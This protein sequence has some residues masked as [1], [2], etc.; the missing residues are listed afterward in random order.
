MNIK[1]DRDIIT[2]NAMKFMLTIIFLS[3]YGLVC[4]CYNVILGWITSPYEP[5]DSL[6]ATNAFVF[7][8][9]STITLCTIARWIFKRYFTPPILVLIYIL[10]S[11]TFI[12]TFSVVIYIR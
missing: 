11:L 6:T 7:G 1:I 12:N 2:Q 4:F 9:T 3:V 8:I 5:A 10:I